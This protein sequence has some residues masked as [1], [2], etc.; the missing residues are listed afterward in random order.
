MGNN[1]KKTVLVFTIFSL[2]L[3]SCEEINLDDTLNKAGLSEAEIAMGLREALKV[4]TDT[5]V[6]LT[7]KVDGF[8]KNELIKIVMPE[9]AKAVESRLRSIGLGKLV[10]DAILSMNRAAE[11]AA[12]QAKDIFVDAITGITIEDAKGILFG[13]SVAATNYLKGKTFD[14]LFSLFAPS[15]K[16]S[17]EKVNATKFWK[18]VF[19]TYNRLPLVTPVNSNLEQYVTDKALGGLFFVVS[20]EEQ[21]IRKD[22][23]ARVNDILKKVFGELDK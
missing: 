3:T 6:N 14:N 21:N 19:D 23:V 5:S 1:I 7:S 10:D 18:D 13:D 9:E 17:L 8:F 11:D 16:N 20:Q 22:P 2:F 12:P 4:G 15:I